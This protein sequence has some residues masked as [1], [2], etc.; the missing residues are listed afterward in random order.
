MIHWFSLI[1]LY[2]YVLSSKSIVD[3][4]KRDSVVTPD[5]GNNETPEVKKTFKSTMVDDES[6]N[7][8]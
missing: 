8:F 1:I 7:G 2:L 6:V 4:R 3:Y 5:V